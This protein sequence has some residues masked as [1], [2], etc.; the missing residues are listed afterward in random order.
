MSTE[1]DRRKWPALIVFVLI[2]FAVAAFGS[3]FSPGEWYRGLD[4]PEFNPPAAVFGPVWTLLYALMALAA[5]L[6]W[7]ARQLRK[8]TPAM[9]AY[10]VQL[11]LNGLWSWVF[12]GRHQI[13]LALVNIIL[14]WAA[15]VVTMLLFWRIRPTATLLLVPYVLWVSFAL[16]LNLRF[17]QLNG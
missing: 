8:I 10:A 2:T 17:W 3:Q 5:W 14:L 7:R 6:V 1:S 11:V 16:L 4:K 12:F 13:G 15:I 9:V